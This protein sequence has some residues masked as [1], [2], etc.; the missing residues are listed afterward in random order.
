MSNTSSILEMRDYHC[1]EKHFCTHPPPKG[2]VM[3]SIHVNSLCYVD[4][5][6][7]GRWLMQYRVHIPVTHRHEISDMLMTKGVII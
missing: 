7:A 5:Q 1:I 2:I 3:A 6:P 4:T